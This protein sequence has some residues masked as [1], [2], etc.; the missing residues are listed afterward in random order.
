MKKTTTANIAGIMFQIDEDAYKEIE[1]YLSRIEASYYNITEAKDII[2]D[3][4][5]RLAELFQN[6]TQSGTKII[7]LSDVNWA[8]SIVG[9]PEDIGGPKS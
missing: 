2:K 1:L 7:T 8:I 9:K 3:I 4:E 6:R 5:T